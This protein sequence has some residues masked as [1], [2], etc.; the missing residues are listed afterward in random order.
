MRAQ[1]FIKKRCTGIL[2][3]LFFVFLTSSYN[4]YSQSDIYTIAR[5]GSVQ[6][7]ETVYKKDAESI[8]TPNDAGYSPLILAAY[9]GNIPVTKRLVELGADIN[10]DSTYGTP[11]MAA[12]VKRNKELVDFFINQKVD[13]DKSD[14]NGT[15]ALHYAAMFGLEDIT[16]ALLEA[17]A[18]P[19][20][21]DQKDF[22]P[23]D[24]AAKAKNETIS[25]LFKTHKK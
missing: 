23:Y 10:G 12:T 4:S 15:T 13:L 11:L 3:F 8:T 22:T 17:G 24:Y 14:Q 16:K 1:L 25:K 9:N 5:S 6:E 21:R 7:L 19:K 18:N 20:A 2:S